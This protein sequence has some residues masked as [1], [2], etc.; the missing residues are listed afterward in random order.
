[1]D[2]QKKFHKTSD[3]LAGISTLVAETLKG[4]KFLRKRSDEL[5]D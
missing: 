5:I 1:V 4:K 2:E 3:K